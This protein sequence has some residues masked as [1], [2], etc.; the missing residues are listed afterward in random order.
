MRFP[1]LKIG[2][3][4][5]RF[6]D[7]LPVKSRLGRAGVCGTRPNHKDAMN[8]EDYMTRCLEL[9]RSALAAGE[10]PVGAVL[11]RDERIVA[12]GVERT[13][14]LLDPAA[15]AEVEAVRS[16]CRGVGSIDLSGS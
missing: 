11:V 2:D 14:Q 1:L 8:D 4:G 3:T 16:A 13:R 15:H 7:G 12:E 6:E 10:V 9:A 5:V